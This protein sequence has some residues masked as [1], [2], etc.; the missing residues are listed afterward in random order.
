MNSI[1]SQNLQESKLN[2]SHSIYPESTPDFNT[3]WKDLKNRVKPI[4][5]EKE[6]FKIKRPLGYLKITH[7]KNSLFNK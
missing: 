3:F 1:N 5:K 4:I 2:I 6:N 7:Y